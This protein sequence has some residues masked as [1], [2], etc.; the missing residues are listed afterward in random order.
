MAAAALAVCVAC[1]TGFVLHK[2]P[3]TRVFAAP[4][5]EIEGEESVVTLNGFTLSVLSLDDIFGEAA[6]G[7]QAPARIEVEKK[8]A[9]VV[10]VDAGHGGAD[11]GCARDGIQEKTINLAI[12]KKVQ[13]KLEE[14]GYNVIMAR[15]GD[16]YIT[17]EN[18][19]KLL[20]D[21]QVLEEE[22]LGCHPCVNTSSL[23]LRTG[24]VFDTFLKEVH[25]EMTVVHLT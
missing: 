9:P 22:F 18:R 1:S 15:E 23:R 14:M 24:D 8:G 20:V 16:T 7:E 19:V 3:L 13:T 4:E 10:F 5:K 25:H 21:A 6:G 12:A 11:G 2:L 17:K